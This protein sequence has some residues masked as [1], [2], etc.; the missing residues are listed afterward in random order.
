MVAHSLHR[1]SQ[2]LMNELERVA[3][4]VIQVIIKNQY[5]PS[6]PTL[7][8]TP[9]KPHCILGRNCRSHLR[10][11]DHK[12]RRSTS[13]TRS[14]VIPDSANPTRSVQMVNPGASGVDT[15]KQAWLAKYATGPS[16]EPSAPGVLS[17]KQ[18]SAILR[19]QFGILPKRK[20]IGYSKPYT[21]D[22]DLIPL[23]PSISFLSSPSSTDQREPA[24]S[25][26]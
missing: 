20:A 9:R 2:S 26:M 6:G 8:V 19:D 16:A 23:H 24:P 13:S 5:S 22:Y 21:S 15:E 7:G 18:V 25:S 3:H 14:A 1:H 17:V 4:R 11:Q 12:I 10:P